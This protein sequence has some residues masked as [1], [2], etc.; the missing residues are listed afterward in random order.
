MVEMSLEEK[1]ARF[2]EMSETATR[3]L[4]ASAESKR[5]VSEHAQEHAPPFRAAVLDRMQ[6]MVDRRRIDDHELLVRG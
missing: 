1:I 5:A 6:G 4:L 2:I 3:N